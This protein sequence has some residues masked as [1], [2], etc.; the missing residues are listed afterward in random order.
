LGS[1]L[2]WLWILGFLL[3]GVDGDGAVAE[4]VD[5]DVLRVVEVDSRGVSMSMSRER[6]W[7]GGRKVISS[8]SE[9]AGFSDSETEAEKCILWSSS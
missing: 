6:G 5:A 7:R 3:L 1:G 9:D 2:G 8:G 4:D